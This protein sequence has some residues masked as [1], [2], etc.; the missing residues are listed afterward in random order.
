MR[1]SG[2]LGWVGGEEGFDVIAPLPPT[3]DGGRVVVVA[4]VTARSPVS[5][6]LAACPNL[7]GRPVARSYAF[8]GAERSFF[9][10]SA[11]LCRGS[12]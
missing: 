5:E 7:F 1:R 10:T 12:S 6:S 9:L 4:A 3:S 11:R 2:L 8:G